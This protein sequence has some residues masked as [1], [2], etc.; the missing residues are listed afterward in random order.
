MPVTQRVTS[1][2]SFWSSLLSNFKVI[3]HLFTGCIDVEV[4]LGFVLS[5]TSKKRLVAVPNGSRICPYQVTNA[6]TADD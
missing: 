1:N 5:L 2:S 3:V 4:I 6:K